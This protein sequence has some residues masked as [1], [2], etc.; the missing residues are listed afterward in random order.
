M[1]RVLAPFLLL[2]GVM[3]PALRAQSP[4]LTENFSTA[5]AARWHALS[6]DW[7]FREGTAAIATTA[8][9]RILAGPLALPGRCDWTIEVSLRGP[10]AGLV[11]GMEDTA[12]HALAHMVRFD[13]NALL[14]GYFSAGGEFI[15]TGTFPLPAAATE[16]TLLRVA[17]SPGKRQYEMFVNGASVGVDHRLLFPAGLAGLQASEGSSQFRSV[18]ITGSMPLPLAPQ[19]RGTPAQFSH[20]RFVRAGANNVTIY[21][22]ADEAFQALDMQGKILSNQ[23]AKS[24]TP[25]LPSAKRFGREFIATTAGISVTE[26]GSDKVSLL[27]LP[28]VAPSALI[29][30][31]DSVIY[32]ADAVQR[33]VIAL[34]PAGRI[35][36]TFTGRSVGGLIAPRGLDF[37]GPSRIVIADDSR[38]ILAG[39]DLAEPLS[40]EAVSATSALCSWHPADTRSPF[41]EWSADGH[42][43]VRSGA[44][45]SG[46]QALVT[47][48]G[49][50]PAT[51]YSLRFSDGVRIIPAAPVRSEEFRFVTP[52]S[53]SSRMLCT[54]LRVLCLVYRSITYRDRYP[55]ER[56][57]RVPD[58]RTLGDSDLTL[59][60]DAC[61]FNREFYFRNSG[62]RLVLDFDFAVVEE[63]LTL[64]DC[65]GTDPYWLSPN[66]RVT[67]DVARAAASFGIP[68]E[69][70]AGVVIPYAWVNYPPRRTSALADPGRIDSVS[71]RQAY[72][73][74]TLGVPA[75]WK[76]GATTGYTANPFQ[77]RFSRQDWLITH[78]FHHQIDALLDASGSPGYH[79]ADQ[80]W[81]M[82]GRFGEDF[83]FN[84]HI[85]RNAPV[86]WWL[87]M[88]FGTLVT[89]AD[90]DGD[91]V[92]D[93]DP[94]L[95][96]D[97][98][99]LGGN[100]RLR[101]TDGDGLSDFAEV[102]AGTS[103]GTSL[104][105]SDTD[106]DG[107]PDGRDP[108]PL[109]PFPPE[110]TRSPT[111]LRPFGGTDGAEIRWWW[112]A[113][114]LWISSV[115]DRPEGLLVQID[116]A[117]DG[118]FHG[119]DNYQVRVRDG[120]RPEDPEYYLRD[121]SSWTDPP[122]DRK[123]ILSPSLLG[124]TSAAEG[125]SAHPRSVLTVRI[126]R[127]EAHGLRLAPGEELGIRIG[128][129]TVNDRWMW[130]ELC[131]RNYMMKVRLR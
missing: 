74:G 88:K 75:P 68:P 54:R 100:P 1:R 121:C 28:L 3:Q 78:E 59:L 16:W 102:M 35:L 108:E 26:A 115:T 30:G 43:S 52:P 6:G 38:L 110:I 40:V 19:R 95:P 107:L 79:H 12:T 70:Y 130:E 47:L 122:H 83:D 116:A 7:T 91:T 21:N 64:A 33:C 5:T 14:S 119:F 120:V 10:R 63:P 76:Y 69:R 18:T 71:I 58:G 45:E 51:R 15:A 96:L 77:D 82:P 22:P 84:A 48:H 124:V 34:T 2:L 117:C 97:E 57:P 101:D 13:D 50:A 94:S 93:D 118:W 55:A 39:T 131:E 53:D 105:N 113:D 125:D 126:P 73:G 32:V 37:V 46:G 104:T 72:G 81:K 114:A 65:G 129:Q 31:R 87:T 98:K 24:P 90:A 20:V 49:L 89:T 42:P 11:F 92:P 106:G 103:H 80:P 67:R 25:T 128:V 61:A 8:Y 111:S 60:K 29:V 109:Y 56:F 86:S 27:P 123:D 17:V 44:Q 23:H 41:V 4:W 66:E 62:C 85:I 127:D 36:A 112:T 9:D 99:R